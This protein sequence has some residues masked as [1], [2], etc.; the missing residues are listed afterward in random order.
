MTAELLKVGMIIDKSGIFD[1]NSNYR[2]LF[3]TIHL[4]YFVLTNNDIAVL[5]KMAPTKMAKNNINDHTIDP[6]YAAMKEDANGI[7]KLKNVK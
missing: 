6:W 2:E 3:P 7:N 5:H 1:C 4:R